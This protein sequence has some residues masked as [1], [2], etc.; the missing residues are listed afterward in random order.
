[1]FGSGYS[2]VTSRVM[3]RVKQTDKYIVL[4]YTLISKFR[5][6]HHFENSEGNQIKYF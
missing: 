3:D 1:M 6:N 2:N 5:L 4:L